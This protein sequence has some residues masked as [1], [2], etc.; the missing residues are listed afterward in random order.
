M[1]CREFDEIAELYVVGELDP[2]SAA[3]AEA[4]LGQCSECGQRL[5]AARRRLA[6]LDA[7]LATHRASGRFVGQTMARVHLLTRDEAEGPE[8]LASRLLRYAMLAAAAMFFVLA[9]YGF[10][11]GRPLAVVERGNV[12][13]VGAESRPVGASSRL[14]PGD[15]VAT[16]AN[17]SATLSLAGGKLRAALGPGT[18]VR[19]MDPRTGAALQVL[20]GE[21]YFRA[22]A[23][24]GVPLVATPLGRV[25]PGPGLVSL[26]VQ[27]QPL[28]RAPGFHGTV[29]LV[30]HD[31][32]AAVAI[33]R[34]RRLVPVRS[35]QV[36]A[37]RTEGGTGLL[38]PTRLERLRQEVD[39]RLAAT[40]ARRNQLAATRQ[41]LAD[42]LRQAPV[43]AQGELFRRVAELEEALRRFDALNAHLLHQRAILEKCREKATA[44]FR[45]LLLP[46]KGRDR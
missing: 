8:S 18:I 24:R 21:V 39:R 22:T 9:G 26:H 30:A 17:S 1:D 6:A 38:G 19:V 29:T 41:Q 36:V 46:S 33:G 40:A 23:S 4:H 7:A 37:L 12:A 13:V 34:T 42:R 11:R 32:H 27:P 45:L 15:I 5:A 3:Q 44:H 35:G 31:G 20:R 28:S 14:S 43:E 25:A 10:L 2:Q 16:P